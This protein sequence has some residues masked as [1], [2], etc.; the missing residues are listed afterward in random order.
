MRNVM[1]TDE[2]ILALDG[3][4]NTEAQ[5]VVERVKAVGEHLGVGHA[6]WAEIV[7]DALA[8]GYLGWQRREGVR[9]SACEA[10]MTYATYKSGPRR[11]RERL[12][13]PR[14]LSC[15]APDY[16]PLAPWEYA[17][18]QLCPA[19]APQAREAIG[20][21]LRAGD[22]PVE[23]AGS[24]WL[25]EEEYTCFR[26]ARTMWQF[27]MGPLPCLLGG[28]LLLRAL[29]VLRGRG[30][31]PGK[32]PPPSPAALAYDAPRGTGKDRQPVVASGGLTPQER[33][34]MEAM[35]AA[36]WQLVREPDGRECALVRC[37]YCGWYNTLM[38][39]KGTWKIDWADGS[40]RPCKHLPH[41]ERPL[42]GILV[43]HQWVK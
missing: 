21:Y 10:H 9:C 27:D 35:R 26:C 14:Y 15:S 43:F 25:R 38:L 18:V 6:L 42:G 39:E 16:R 20:A 31:A 23:T 24:A 34:T 22:L 12:D 28:R 2:E 1:L 30:V 11:G 36:N 4:V 13:K 33:G 29:P 40:T 8:T 41:N 37:P 17:A 5:A 32:Q 7:V 19:C 3:R